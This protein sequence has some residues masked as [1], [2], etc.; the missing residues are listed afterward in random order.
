MAAN[1]GACL[2]SCAMTLLPSSQKVFL[3]SQPIDMRKSYQGLSVLAE[4]TL[5]QDPFSGH[6]FVFYNKRRDRLKI[7]YWHMNGFCILQKRLEKGRFQISVSQNPTMGISSYQLQ[8]LIQGIDWEKI[9]EPKTA[10]YRYL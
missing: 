8:G 5:R 2:C 4:Q 3:A 1:H 9:P 7:L 10:S 6:L